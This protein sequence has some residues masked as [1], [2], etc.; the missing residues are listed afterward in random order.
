ML[1]LI[2]KH[3]ISYQRCYYARIVL[4]IYATTL[5]INYS[6]YTHTFPKKV[7]KNKVNN[8]MQF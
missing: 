2:S 8:V 3:F 5:D 4:Q 1:I 6:L 7:R